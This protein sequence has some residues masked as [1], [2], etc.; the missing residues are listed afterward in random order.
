[1]AMPEKIA[2]KLMTMTKTLTAIS[3]MNSATAAAPKSMRPCSTNQI[4]R[5]PA[6]AARTAETMARTPS[7]A[8]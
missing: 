6:L 5:S 2:Q 4:Q 1:M 8:E 3:G 7:D